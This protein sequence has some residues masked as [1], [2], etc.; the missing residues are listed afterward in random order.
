MFTLEISDLGSGREKIVCSVL[1]KKT[2]R[3]LQLNFRDGDTVEPSGGAAPAGTALAPV[4]EDHLGPIQPAHSNICA[5]G[6]VRS[7]ESRRGIATLTAP[8][9]G[10]NPWGGGRMASDRGR[11]RRAGAP[12]GALR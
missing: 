10:A 5:R 9:H 2:G 4:E 6:R 7:L 11:E 1:V 3:R 12:R 8:S